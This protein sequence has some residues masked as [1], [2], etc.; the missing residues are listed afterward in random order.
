[1]K[2]IEIKKGLKRNVC[3]QKSNTEKSSEKVG[4]KGDMIREKT[5]M[6]MYS[7]WWMMADRVFMA[8]L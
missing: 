4:P 6:M 2:W 5:L 7:E 1:M 8:A 3:V